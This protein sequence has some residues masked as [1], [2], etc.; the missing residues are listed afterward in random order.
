MASKQSRILVVDDHRMMLNILRF[1]LQRAGFTVNTARNGRAAWELVQA[2]DF[3]LLITDYQ[4]P[5]MNGEM[6]I[7]QIREVDRLKSL[8]I[9][10]LSAK[11]LELDLS[12][13]REELGVSEVIYKPFSPSGLVA[14]AEASLS[15]D[16]SVV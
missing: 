16:A 15:R 4:M 6:L 12:R 13:L 14:T 10:L 8:P 1:T 2:E 9:I 5:E 11:G 7:Q 3:D